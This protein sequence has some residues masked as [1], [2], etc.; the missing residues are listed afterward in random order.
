MVECSAVTI[1][2]FLIILEHGPQIFILNYVACS[3][4]VVS[5]LLARSFSLPSG[6]TDPT[7]SHIQQDRSALGKPLF[8]KGG[9]RHAPAPPKPSRTNLSGKP[10]AYC[11]MWV[12]H[13]TALSFLVS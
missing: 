4:F 13:S 12:S 6:P 3:A 2:K 11:V 1:L 10:E 9:G 8:L 5:F 7:L